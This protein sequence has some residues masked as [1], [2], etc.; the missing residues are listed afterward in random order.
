[1]KS[2]YCQRKGWAQQMLAE[3]YRPREG[4]GVIRIET[5]HF[6]AECRIQGD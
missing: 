2:D 5:L 3:R 1:M 6:L 4:S